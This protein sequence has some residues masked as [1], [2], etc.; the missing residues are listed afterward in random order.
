MRVDDDQGRNE[1]VL[2]CVTLFK[3]AEIVPYCCHFTSVYAY[4]MCVPTAVCSTCFL[5]QT[6]CGRHLRSNLITLLIFFPSLI[7]LPLLSSSFT[8]FLL[9]T[10]V[11]FLLSSFSFLFLHNFISDLLFFFLLPELYALYI[12]YFVSLFSSIPLYHPPF[13]FNFQWSRREE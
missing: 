1:S 8:L 13:F 12:Y 9:Y 7:P 2:A 6:S 4:C 3:C 5:L 10:F 11:S